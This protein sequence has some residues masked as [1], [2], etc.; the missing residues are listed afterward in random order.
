M[1]RAA[2]QGF[3]ATGDEVVAVVRKTDDDREERVSYPVL[4]LRM[5]LSR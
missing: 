1:N 4:F 2:R 5:C 3:H